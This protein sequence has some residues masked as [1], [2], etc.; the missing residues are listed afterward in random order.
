VK[1]H[2]CTAYRVTGIGLKG[3]HVGNVFAILI[4]TMEVTFTC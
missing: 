3:Q 1:L 4:H 2:F